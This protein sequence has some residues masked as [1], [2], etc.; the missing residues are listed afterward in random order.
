MNVFIV[1]LNNSQSFS[2]ILELSLNHFEK[3][4]KKLKNTRTKQ[5]FLKKIYGK[6]KTFFFFFF[7]FTK[8]FIFRIYFTI[9]LLF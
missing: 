5:V 7:F 8:N 3:K 6:I 1:I 9:Y 2:T 4:K